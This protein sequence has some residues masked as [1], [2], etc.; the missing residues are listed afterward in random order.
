MSSPDVPDSQ[1]PSLGGGGNFIDN[2]R[3][4]FGPTP[5]LI[6]FLTAGGVTA[7]QFAKNDAGAWPTVVL[8]LG[9]IAA[10]IYC[11]KNHIR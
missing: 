9:A 6:A 10:A 8:V 3:A 1:P 7:I 11:A 4:R 5:A 2:L